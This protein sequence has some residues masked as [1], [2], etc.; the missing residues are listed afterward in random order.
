MDTTQEKNRL[1]MSDQV[2]LFQIILAPYAPVSLEVFFDLKRL[3]QNLVWDDLHCFL[4]N[5]GR[6]TVPDSWILPQIV[7]GPAK[8]PAVGYSSKDPLHWFEAQTNDP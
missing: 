3:I 7:T 6:A 8:G 4:Q 2:P 5:V 1:A